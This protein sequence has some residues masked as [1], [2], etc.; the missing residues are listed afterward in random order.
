MVQVAEEEECRRFSAEVDIAWIQLLIDLQSVEKVLIQGL[1]QQAD[2]PLDDRLTCI[3]CAHARIQ[4]A[5]D[6]LPVK[7]G[8]PEEATTRQ[9]E[10]Q[11]MEYFTHQMTD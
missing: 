11:V 8:S 7:Y 2:V 1:A 4:S 3:E 6:Q 5:L 10:L 9:K